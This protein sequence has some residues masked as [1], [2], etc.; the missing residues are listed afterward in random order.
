MTA[1]LLLIK[2]ENG[3]ETRQDY[4]GLSD[5]DT[6]GAATGNSLAIGADSVWRPADLMPRATIIAAGQF[7]GFVDRNNVVQK[8]N[9]A[10]RVVTNEH[11]S[12]FVETSWNGII[13]RH[14]S[15]WVLPAHPETPNRTYF[16]YSTDGTN[17]AWSETLWEF[18][19]IQV[20][21][22]EHGTYLKLPIRECHGLADPEWHRDAHKHI[23]TY[24]QSGCGL[25]AGTYAIG[26]TASDPNNTPGVDAGILRDEDLPTAVA[27]LA[28]GSYRVCRP[29]SGEFAIDS[30]S[31]PFPFSAGTY[32]QY[33]PTDTA[34]LGATGKFYNVY[35]VGAPLMLTETGAPHPNRFL[36]IAPQAQY[37]S[38]TA[39]R[40]ESF[41]SLRLGNLAV[42]T[43]EY[44][45]IRRLIFGTSAAYGTTGKVRLDAVD[46]LER[47]PLRS[48]ASA[49]S[50]LSGS[51]V[52]GQPA[53]WASP[54]SLTSQDAA[55][56]RGTIGALAASL[57]GAANGVAELGADGR[58]P[59]GQLPSYVD[60]VLEYAN[61]AAFPATGETGKIYIN[62]DQNK[63]WRWSGSGYTEIS[64]S[65]ALGE[66]SATAYRGDHGTTAY[67]HSQLTTGNPHGTTPSDI[68]ALPTA[69]PT[70]TGMLAGPNATLSGLSASATKLARIGTGGVIE[71][72]NITEDFGDLGGASGLRTALSRPLKL[73]QAG[74]SWGGSSYSS[75]TPSAYLPISD[76]SLGNDIS[77]TR[78]GWLWNSQR[79]NA[80]TI[81]DGAASTPYRGRLRAERWFAYST[82]LVQNTTTATSWF[83][84]GTG[85]GSATIPANYLKPGRRVNI[86]GRLICSSCV[87]DT[88]PEIAF[89]IGSTVVWTQAKG[90][91]IAAGNE[92][93]VDVEIVMFIDSDGN[94]IV[95][96]DCEFF[97]YLTG[98]YRIPRGNTI[99]AFDATTAKAIDLTL[100]PSSTS[101][102]W[103]R[104]IALIEI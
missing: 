86:R 19:Y 65:L 88:N 55:I 64:A 103:V 25:T 4:G 9:E 79:I 66:T 67:T 10:T 57:K 46:E 8:Y 12:G 37:G 41:E 14:A 51:G 48:A 1:K 100:K 40:A 76:D 16:Y 69:S 62:L 71:A 58:V 97:S 75:W 81:C 87:A 95:L 45:P 102:I 91:T 70:F 20:A 32:I 93:I 72:G 90:F 29:L 26:G 85:D 50:V 54:S 6:T 28:Q 77:G 31:V 94:L 92:I 3:L 13:T 11:A 5:V 17:Y 78:S 53:V 68:G 98:T 2:S 43:S 82:L 44:C 49:A 34:A 80:I 21:S 89:K 101:E 24:V 39:A 30:L 18:E 15:P 63:T 61:L 22:I 99:A 38:I 104:S 84:G 52:A 60:D 35:L 23:W 33:F 59:S 36:W 96:S 74:G 47:S 27:A 7:S 83:A 42:G 56:F 73:N